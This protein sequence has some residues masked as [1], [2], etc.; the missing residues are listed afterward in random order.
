MS[1]ASRLSQYLAD[2]Q[3]DYEVVEHFAAPSSS[4]TAEAAH[5]PGDRLAKAVL[6]RDEGGCLLAVVPST[7]QIDLGAVRALVH[8]QLQLASESELG[9]FFPDCDLG[10]APPV[11][12]AYTLDT[13]ADES[14]KGQ[15]D[16]Y[17]EAGDHHRLIKV[18]EEAFAKLMASALWGHFSHHT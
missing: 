17:F 6:L 11:G 15:P 16:V 1:I 3:V 4:R 2:A 10:A 8:R 5:V 18:S 7:H 13:I 9:R 12:A 14:L